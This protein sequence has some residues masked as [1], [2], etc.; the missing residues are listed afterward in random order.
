MIVPDLTISF[1]ASL[2]QGASSLGARGRGCRR[3]RG[4]AIGRVGSRVRRAGAVPSSCSGRTTT[5][6]SPGSP[7]SRWRASCPPASQLPVVPTHDNSSRLPRRDSSWSSRGS[8]GRAC[9]R[10]RGAARGAR[11]VDAFCASARRRRR[12]PRSPDSR[13]CCFAASERP[14]R[15]AVAVAPTRTMRAR[16]RWSRVGARAVGSEEPRA[17]RVRNPAY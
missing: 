11:P 3:D 2:I 15:L 17:G 5:R 13:R 4:A 16:R 6:V 8:R 1:F 10:D 12:S 7:I 14:R 9:R